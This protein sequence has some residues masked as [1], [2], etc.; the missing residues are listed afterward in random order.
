[1][2]K[3]N[4]IEFPFK[5]M[6][7]FAVFALIMSGCGNK[8]AE[9]KDEQSSKTTET[10]QEDVDSKESLETQDPKKNEQ[11]VVRDA[12][13][14]IVGQ[15]LPKEATYISD[16]LIASKRYPL[17]ADFAPGEDPEARAA[18]EELNAAGILEGYTFNAFSTYRSYDRQV[19]LYANYVNRDGKE[20]ADTYSARPGYSEHQT[21]L[22]FDIGEVG[23]EQFFADEG[24]GKTEAGKWLAKNAHKY[25][26]IMRYPK[27]KENVTGYMHESWH[28]RYVGK[29][30]AKDIYNNKSTLEEYLEIEK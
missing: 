4:H 13:G 23:S 2:S 20:A 10:F 16:L 28:F 6:A 5:M 3:N 8:D 17:P 26:F 27:G 24:F 15:E 25:G 18:F 7:S 12:G 21:G 1:M 30:I 29:D 19:E 22:A 14:Y 11:E 9:N